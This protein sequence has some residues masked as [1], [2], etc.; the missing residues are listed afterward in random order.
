MAVD[1][2]NGKQAE[3]PGEIVM[4]L[5][6]GLLVRGF[7]PFNDPPD[8]E[9]SATSTSDQERRSRSPLR[10][11][12]SAVKTPATLLFL[13]GLTTELCLGHGWGQLFWLPFF[14]L[15]FLQRKDWELSGTSKWIGRLFLVS[16]FLYG[17]LH[18]FRR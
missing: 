10:K 14:V 13:L 16:C 7:N 18:S 4:L 1:F 9:L 2:A 17:L 6:G 11:L 5:D 3:F 15:A 12:L 8:F